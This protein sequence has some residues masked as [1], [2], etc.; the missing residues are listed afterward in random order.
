MSD[1][2]TTTTLTRHQQCDAN[3][4]GSA[5]VRAFRAVCAQVA[6]LCGDD[7]SIDDG[8]TIDAELADDVV[9]DCGDDECADVTSDDEDDWSSSSSSVRSNRTRRNNLVSRSR[10]LRAQLVSSQAHELTQQ[11]E[12]TNLSPDAFFSSRRPHSIPRRTD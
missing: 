12:Q 8:A 4:D 5:F 6:S 1:Q 3:D 2:K 9:D 10:L 7:D 11:K